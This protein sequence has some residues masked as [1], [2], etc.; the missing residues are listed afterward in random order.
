MR[1]LGRLFL[2]LFFWPF[3]LIR[4]FWKQGRLGKLFAGVWI[5]VFILYGYLFA[6]TASDTISVDTAEQLVS[7]QRSRI[8][9]LRSSENTAAPSKPVTSRDAPVRRLPE[10]SG[11]LIRELPAGVEL[12]LV[13]ISADA[14]WYL[15]EAGG[16]V[17]E[18][19]F[20]GAPDPNLP[21][22][23][24][25]PTAT[26]TPESTDTPLPTNTYTA[27]PTDTPAPTATHTP[28][29]P[30]TPTAEPIQEESS[31]PIMTSRDAPIRRRPGRFG[32]VIRELPAGVELDLVGISDDA[33]WYLLEEGGWIHE[34]NF[35]GDPDPNLPLA[36]PIPTA[37]QTPR[38]TQT[39]TGTATVTLTPTVTHTPLPTATPSLTPVPTSTA[40]PSATPVP[41]DTAVPTLPPT[42]TA[43][44]IPIPTATTSPSGPHA[45]RVANLREGPSTAYAI[46]GGVTEGEVLDLFGRNAAGDW[47]QLS[48][49]TWIAAFLV[50]N[51]P[52]DLPVTATQAQLPGGNPEPADSGD[53]DAGWSTVQRG[54]EFR[55]DCPC[56]QGNI[57]NCGDFGPGYD[58]QAC[59][60]KCAEETGRDVHRLDGDSDGSA[61]E[62]NW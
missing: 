40:I 1:F 34:F 37:T 32:D 23:A 33:D 30:A 22:V 3:L 13:G 38:P 7:N 31:P 58:A 51:A 41:T 42:A 48:S 55:S 2:W 26:N 4:W 44:S 46:V 62:W 8:E 10:R 54:Y 11:E 50:N 53:G 35:R 49:G 20:R 5:A 39:P 15:L 19:N 43:T 56:N 12:N 57:L 18:F 6:S 25:A 60:L 27:T 59:F 47:Y 52:A 14:D 28:I 36:T 21:L 16:W 29:P 24:P 45:N 17:H 9:L 61:C